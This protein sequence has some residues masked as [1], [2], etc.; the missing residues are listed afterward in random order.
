MPRWKMKQKKMPQKSRNKRCKVED[1]AE[2]KQPKRVSTLAL[3]HAKIT[4]QKRAREG[5]NPH[6]SPNRCLS[7][8]SD[9]EGYSL[10]RHPADYLIRVNIKKK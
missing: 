8:R 9:G 10:A 1:R 2:K 4:Q 3:R 5:S 7:S 6:H